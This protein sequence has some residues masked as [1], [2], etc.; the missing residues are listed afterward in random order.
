[1]TRDPTRPHLRLGLDFG[2]VIVRAGRISTGVGDDTV[3]DGAAD[4]LD[5]AREGALETVA[6]LV[7][8]TGGQVWVV[9]KAR[10]VMQ[11]RSRRWLEEV[12]FF[13]RTGFDPEH[14]HF[15]RLLLSRRR[16]QLLW[17]LASVRLQHAVRGLAHEARLP[18]PLVGG[19]LS[20]LRRG[21][22]RRDRLLQRPALHS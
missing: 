9:S 6:E 11:E 13:E 17:A 1:M 3:F 14:L 21:P 12:R 15:C 20:P 7:A 22:Q 2:G 10:P 4:P 16:R 5:Q 8:A 19:G 18:F